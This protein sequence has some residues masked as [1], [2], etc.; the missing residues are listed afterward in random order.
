MLLKEETLGTKEVY[1]G[2]IFRV[3]EAL[4]RLPNGQEGKRDVVRH[5]GA[6]ALLAWQ[7]KDTILL[8]RQF[9]YATGE[10]LWEIPA[11]KLEPGEEAAQCAAR[12][13]AEETGFAPGELQELVRFYTSPGFSSELLYLYEARNLR[14]TD[15]E[16]DADEFLEVRGIPFPI[17][18]EWL[19]EGRIKDAKTLVALL[20]A[21]CRNPA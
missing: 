14:A 1:Q 5:P 3:E 17:A 4:V 19:K 11:G 6:V 2:R 7:D 21:N 8:V 9:R 15:G 16:R 10:E 13:L 18:L 20:W 12:E